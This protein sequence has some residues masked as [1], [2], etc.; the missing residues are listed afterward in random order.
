[1]SCESYVVPYVN[2]RTFKGN[3]IYPKLSAMQVKWSHNVTSQH[4]TTTMCSCAA[5]Q[6]TKWVRRRWCQ[7]LYF[8]PICSGVTRHLNTY[9]T[10]NNLWLVSLIFGEWLNFI[11]I[12][13]RK[14]KSQGFPLKICKFKCYCCYNKSA[15]ELVQTHH[16]FL[17]ISLGH[18][19]T[20]RNRYTIRKV[21]WKIACFIVLSGICKVI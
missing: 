6:C 21:K 9:T 4:S 17:F 1:M 11:F 20:Y 12:S 2:V 19:N 13:L 15:S 16:Y 10:P 14:W 5:V 7:S 3:L 8:V 18:H